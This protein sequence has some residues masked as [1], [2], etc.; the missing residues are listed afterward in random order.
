M[1]RL[2]MFNGALLPEEEARL[3]VT[4]LVVRRG[5]AIFDF[6]RVRNGHP[7]YME[8]HLRRFMNGAKDT[9][10][11]PGFRENELRDQV[12]A[13]V[14]AYE[15]PY[16]EGAVRIV[17]T[18][19]EAPWYPESPN[20]VITY[21]P[22]RNYDELLYREG[23][24]V[25]THQFLRELPEIKTVSYMTAVSLTGRMRKAGA[26]EVL[27]H[28]DGHV[29]EFSRSNIFI[30]RGGVLFTPAGQVLAGITRWL[31]LELARSIMPVQETRISM[32]EVLAADEVFMTSTIKRIIPVVQVDDTRIGKGLPGGITRSLMDMLAE[33]DEQ[34]AGGVKVD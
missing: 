33:R 32:D 6:F 26:T 31:V 20:L 1:K 30:V 29:H 7:L 34:E 22:L 3:P 5:F 24:R 16:A 27:Y 19:G 9:G 14:R 15:E 8:Y 21:E 18:G 28:Q 2:C 13:L 11:D 10:M 23:S 25:I 4:D 12:N 17:L